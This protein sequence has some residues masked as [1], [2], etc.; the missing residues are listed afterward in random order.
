MVAGYTASTGQL[1][2]DRPWTTAPYAG[3]G[4]GETFELHGLVPPVLDGVNDLHALI[5][6]A[7]KTILLVVEVPVV[8]TA[9][10]QRHALG[11]CAPWLTEPAFVYEVGVLGATDDREELDPFRRPVRGSAEVDG[12]GV[13][14]N[15]PG[16]T[17]RADDTL[18]VRLL[19]PAYHHC[20]APGGRSATRPGSRSR[21]TRRCPPWS[22]SRR[23]TLVQA[24]LRLANV[25]APA[26]SGRADQELAKAAAQASPLPAELSGGAPTEAHAPPAPR[27]GPARWR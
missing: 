17:F 13:Y 23:P 1:S 11:T 7:L 19:K 10:A 24:W 6:E 21:T 2:P 12:G 5:N 25:L 3:G 15:H 14:L 27:V 16:R 4:V 9:G 20:R 22:G 26:D 18:Y 8:P